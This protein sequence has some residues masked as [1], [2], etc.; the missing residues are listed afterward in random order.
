MKYK[1]GEGSWTTAPQATDVGTYTVQYYLDG[2]PYANNSTTYSKEVTIAPPVV[3]ATGLSGV[4]SQTE[5]K[6][7]LNWSVGDI[8][9]NYANYQWTVYRNDTRKRQYC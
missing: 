1:V 3:R 8:P 6:V 4:F 5:K 9:G 7:T 2:T